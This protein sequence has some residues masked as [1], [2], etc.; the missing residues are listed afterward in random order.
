[1]NFKSPLNF[2]NMSFISVLGLDA[3]TFLQGQISCDVTQVKNAEGIL[4]TYCNQKGRVTAIFTLFKIDDGY[5]L[6]MP[7]EVIS[8]TMAQLKKYSIFSKVSIEHCENYFDETISENEWRLYAI[9]SSIPLIYKAT[10]NLFT[11]HDLSLQLTEAIDFDKGCYLGQ[12]IIARMHYRGKLK[13]KLCQMSL[14]SDKKIL[15]GDEVDGGVV[16]DAICCGDNKY[17]VL[18]VGTDCHPCEGRGPG[19][20]GTDS[21][22]LH[23]Q[24]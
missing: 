5:L 22:P 13:K 20:G 23:S 10:M 21:G 8:D 6:R 9:E 2:E 4:G 17:K 18:I 1:M 12:E 11:P 15:P 7:A 24:G 3:E 19:S 14:E 16:V